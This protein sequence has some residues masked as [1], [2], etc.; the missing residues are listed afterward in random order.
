MEPHINDPSR[1]KTFDT[2]RPHNTYDEI[3]PPLNF[4]LADKTKTRNKT[5]QR[6]MTKQPAV[7]MSHIDISKGFIDESSYAHL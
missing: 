3:K 1:F 5:L 7:I 4:K 6:I 2:Y